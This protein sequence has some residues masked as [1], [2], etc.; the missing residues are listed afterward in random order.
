MKPPKAKIA[1]LRSIPALS[2]L[3][4]RDAVRLSRVFDE[5]DVPPGTVLASAGRPIHELVLIADGE[6]K[7]P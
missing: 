7:R 5:L 1:L 6:A 3:A 4:D 2:V